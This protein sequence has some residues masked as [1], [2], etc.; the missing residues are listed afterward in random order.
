MNRA[1]SWV[2]MIAAI[3]LFG[4]SFFH[5]SW[6]A[7]DPVGAPRLIAAK[8]V[9]PPVNSAGCVVSGNVGYG[10]VAVSHDVGALQ[11]AAGFM[12]DAVHVPVALNGDALQVAPQF[13]RKCAADKSMDASDADAVVSAITK[14]EIFWRVKG[15]QSGKA[16]ANKLPHGD[17]RH[18]IIGDA[19]ANK[20]LKAAHPDIRTIDVAAA[21]AC[22]AEY[23]LSGLWGSMPAIC[24]NHAMLLTLDDLGL[25]LWGWPNRLIARAA[26]TNTVLI[27]A[28]SVTGD[29]IKGLSD[30]GQ[31]GQIANSYNGYIWVQDISE[32]GPALQR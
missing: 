31:Y 20:A 11:A 18:I 25:S 2:L 1:I 13:E 15:E 12:A 8:G 10:M 19:A 27:I 22:A 16:L 29:A 26:A 24:K 17:K 6:L 14:P 28:E 32:L 4:L 30:V 5:A 9:A 3:I 23:K 21:R 7:G